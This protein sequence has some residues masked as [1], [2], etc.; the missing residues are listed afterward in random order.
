M[1]IAGTCAREHRRGGSPQPGQQPGIVIPQQVQQAVANAA[2]N[3]LAGS[4]S[5]QF[6][7]F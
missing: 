3:Q 5:K 6:K 7:L 2:V 1:Y 4:L